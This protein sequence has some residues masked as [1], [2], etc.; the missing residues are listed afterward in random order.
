MVNRHPR[1]PVLAVFNHKGGVAK[2]TTACNMALCLAARGWRCLL[3]DLDAQG[4]AG[5]SLGFTPPPTP[6]AGVTDLVAGH[7]APGAGLVDTV[8]PNL[9]LLPAGG[10]SWQNE[11]ADPATLEFWLAG[12]AGDVVVVDCP[13]ALGAA[14][15]MALTIADAI[16]MPTRPDPLAHQGLTHTWYET[17][18]LRREG[19]AHP[20]QA[21]IL[22]TLTDARGPLADEALA[23]RAE[24]GPAVLDAAIPYDTAISEATRMTVPVVLFEPDGGAGRAYVDATAEIVRRLKLGPRSALPA[25]PSPET[26]LNTLRDWRAGRTALRRLPHVDNRPPPASVARPAPK[27]A[28]AS[29]PWIIAAL[30]IGAVLGAALQA[31]LGSP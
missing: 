26:L 1:P 5:A 3:I 15:R 20:V 14:T 17:K 23:I 7:L 6:M 21:M 24:F 4:N 18:R 22:L 10:H 31:L 29:R 27:P 9:S 11:R 25:S 13:P 16:I 12:C 30:L 8:Y 28:G 19:S 2:T